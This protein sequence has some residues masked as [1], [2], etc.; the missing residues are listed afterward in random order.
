[1][2]PVRETAIELD[3]T[4]GDETNVTNGENRSVHEPQLK[5]NSFGQI[6]FCFQQ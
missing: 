3:A 4:R 2:Q 5:D 1:M 6:A